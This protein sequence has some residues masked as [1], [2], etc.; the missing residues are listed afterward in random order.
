MRKKMGMYVWILA[1][2]I[3][4]GFVGNSAAEIRPGAFTVSPMVGGYKFDDDKSLLDYGWSYSLGLGYN[5]NR[6]FSTEL[7]LSLIHTDADTAWGGSNDVYAY[8]A[9]LDGLCHLMPEKR[10]DPYLALGVG[11]L[12]YD[13]DNLSGVG[14]ELDDIFQMNFGMGLNYFI[15]D[16]V[17]LRADARYL[18]GFEE[19]SD[20]EF[21]FTFGMAF[22]FG[23]KEGP[24]TCKADND[25][26]GVCDDVDQCLNTP[27]GS[28]VDSVGCEIKPYD[29]MQKTQGSDE[30]LQ[31]SDQQKIQQQIPA[32]QVTVYYEFDKTEIK[33]EYQQQLEEL[34]RLMKTYPDIAA[35]VEGYTCNVGSQEYNMTLSKERAKGVMQFLVDKYSLDP[36]RFDVKW[37][38]EAYPAESNATADG[39]AANR[40]TVTT[41]SAITVTIIK[42]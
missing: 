30:A 39:R 2:V 13:D 37:H 25:M 41:T 29:L 11:G 40:R 34:A 23:G 16:N 20:Q 27:R 14:K 18:Y 4:I 22:Q 9:R 17:A 7:G 26:D 33:P 19:E 28:R 3:C 1:A 36:A 6:V 10:F 35:T 15:T 5:I 12:F 32:M 8:Q 38:G 42:K 21:L 31:K 24:P